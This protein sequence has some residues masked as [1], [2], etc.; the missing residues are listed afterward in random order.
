MI[1]NV[2]EMNCKNHD[3]VPLGEK[4]VSERGA[5]DSLW[6]NSADCAVK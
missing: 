6:Q 1:L 3:G 5:C 4:N 2:L